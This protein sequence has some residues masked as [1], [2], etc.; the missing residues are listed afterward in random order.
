[1]AV[2]KIS[3]I[4]TRKI[5]DR[6]KRLSDNPSRNRKIREIANIVANKCSHEFFS[7]FRISLKPLIAGKNDRMRPMKK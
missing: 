7:D 3:E 1:M 2:L 5:A 6:I 4:Q